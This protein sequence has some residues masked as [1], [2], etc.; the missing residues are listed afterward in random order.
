ML[1]DARRCEAQ[2]LR[3]APA[4]ACAPQAM[5]CPAASVGNLGS[6]TSGSR[7]NI[8][9]SSGSGGLPDSTESSGTSVATIV[10]Q[11]QALDAQHKQE[12]DDLM[13][14]HRTEVAELKA[15]LSVLRAERGVPL[16]EPKDMDAQKTTAMR[17]PDSIFGAE[18]A[19]FI[20]LVKGTLEGKDSPHYAQLYHFLLKCF[21]D[22]DNNFDGRVGFKEFETMVECAAFLPRRYG[23]TPSTPE[24]YQTDWDRLKQRM[25]LFNALAQKKKRSTARAIGEESYISFD[26][27]LEY[28]V[29][30]ITEKAAQLKEVETVSKM[31]RSKQDFSEFIIAAC[32]SR[33]TKEYKELYH[34]LLKCFTDADTDMDGL[35]DVNDFYDLIDIAAS[36]P[37]RFGFA[38]PASQIYSSEEERRQARAAIFATLDR[39]GRGHIHFDTWLHYIYKHICEKT[40]VLGES[41]IVPDILAPCTAT[42]N[43]VSPSHTRLRQIRPAGKSGIVLDGPSA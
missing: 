7:P 31:Q 25:T 15:K 23:Y 24:L 16:E 4:T 9:L 18:K 39:A 2:R 10:Q 29:G 32:Q 43:A 34:F 42:G 11:I 38:P 30:H 19:Q 13:E 20:E 22:A 36:A 28:A 27:W 33:K 1:K 41:G 12:I 8:G 6:G 37:R 3:L 26:V 40:A 35:I 14:Q 21:T 17:P 5:A